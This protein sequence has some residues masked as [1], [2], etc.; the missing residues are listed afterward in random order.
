MTNMIWQPSLYSNSGEFNVSLDTKFAKK[1]INV[2]IS[3]ENQNRFN[4][5]GNRELEIMKVKWENP[6]HFH[7]NTGFVKEFYIGHNG[8]WL[9]T[10]YQT[11]DSLLKNDKNLKEIKY[12]S[13]NVDTRAESH[14][15]MVL[16]GKWIEYSDILLENP[17]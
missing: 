8:V 14:A 6:Y 11:V 12:F 15:L 4:L 7:E 5:I 3:A 10:N 13:H 1:M 17:K 2:K 16:F 9:A